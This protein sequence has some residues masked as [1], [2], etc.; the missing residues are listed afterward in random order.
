MPYKKC[1]CCKQ[2]K[3]IDKF[4]KETRA[5][6][7]HKVYC[8][9]CQAEKQRDYIKRNT[10]ERSVKAKT[11][12]E[13]KLRALQFKRLYNLTLTEYEDIVKKQNNK[14]KICLTDFSLLSRKNIHVDHDHSSGKVRGLLCARCNRVLGLLEESSRIL[15]GMIQ[16][17]ESN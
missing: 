12:Y 6:D 5:K 14:C 7:G 3:D 4:H 9:I 10:K 16:Y 1:P 13:D 15:Y 17:L 8:K 11:Y 2:V